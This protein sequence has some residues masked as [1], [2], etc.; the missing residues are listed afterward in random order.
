MV[1]TVRWY[2]WW[3]S[4]NHVH[5]CQLLLKNESSTTSQSR[6]EKQARLGTKWEGI[7]CPNLPFNGEIKDCGG[8]HPFQE[9]PLVDL[10]IVGL[11]SKTQLIWISEQHIDA[12]GKVPG[13]SYWCIDASI[14]LRYII[15]VHFPLASKSSSHH[16]LDITSCV[17][18]HLH[19]TLSFRLQP[20]QCN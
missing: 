9:T 3:I 15:I 12:S 6:V 11:H 1:V 14:F 5:N 10:H 13:H 17:F 4:F 20:F 19:T 16:A 2:S 8:T 7:R 18:Y